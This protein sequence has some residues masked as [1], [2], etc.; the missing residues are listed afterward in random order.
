[1]RIKLMKDL[2]LF[3]ITGRKALVTGGAVGV[4]RACAT[5]LAMGGADVLIADCNEVVGEKTAAS[6]TRHRLRP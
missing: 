1:M 5:A 2:S 6:R 4:G 3:D